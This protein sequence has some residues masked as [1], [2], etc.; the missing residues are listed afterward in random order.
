MMAGLTANA[1]YKLADVPSGITND[2]STASALNMPLSRVIAKHIIHCK[3]AI[4]GMR[5]RNTMK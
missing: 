3:V 2:R 5:T 4:N 1:N